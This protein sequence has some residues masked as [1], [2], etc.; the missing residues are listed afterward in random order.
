MP[1]K[2]PRFKQELVAAFAG[3]VRFPYYPSRYRTSVTIK[4]ALSLR[5]VGGRARPVN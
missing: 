5:E 1:G 2:E 4:P 3:S